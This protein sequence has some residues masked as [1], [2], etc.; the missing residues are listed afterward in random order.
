MHGGN[1]STLSG[2]EGDLKQRSRCRKRKQKKQRKD[3]RR[4]EEQDET[5]MVYPNSRVDGQRASEI[6]W[7]AWGACPCFACMVCSLADL[8]GSLAARQL[9]EMVVGWAL[10]KSRNRV[11]AEK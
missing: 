8:C 2:W 5:K 3:R 1:E 9:F 10:G 6:G 11:Q 7:P 4:Q